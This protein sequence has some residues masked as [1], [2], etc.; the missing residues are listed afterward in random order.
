MGEKRVTANP[1]DPASLAK[2]L[3]GA[4]GAYFVTFFWEHFSTEKEGQEVK[5]YAEAAK[6][7]GIQH[8]IWSTLED[9]RK[10][11]PLSDDSMPTLQGNYKVPHFDAKGNQIIISRIWESRQ[12]LFWLPITWRT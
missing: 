12:H 6:A 1:D 2:A 11:V 3:E 9:T 10:W 7:A 8:A 4:Y 5:N